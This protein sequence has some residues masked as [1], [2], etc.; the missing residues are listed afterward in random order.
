MLPLLRGERGKIFFEDGWTAVEGRKGLIAVFA[1]DHMTLWL[2]KN[3]YQMKESQAKYAHV[4]YLVSESV[5]REGREEGLACHVCVCVSC[6]F[7]CVCD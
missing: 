2:R 5:C 4:S 7:V 1:C 3:V 6:R